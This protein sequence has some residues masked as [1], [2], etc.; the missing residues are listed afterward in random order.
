MDIEPTNHE[1]TIHAILTLDEF[2]ES[3]TPNLLSHLALT[4]ISSEQLSTYI[5]HPDQQSLF[6]TLSSSLRSLVSAHKMSKLVEEDIPGLDKETSQ[7]TLAGAIMRTG[8]II[9]Y[10]T[11]KDVPT[12]IPPFGWD[13][14]QKK[15]DEIK[16][17]ITPEIKDAA[18][19]IIDNPNEPH[20]VQS[21]DL[22][23]IVAAIC[24]IKV[25][26]KL[27]NITNE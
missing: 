3:D 25:E 27:K 21:K 26:N 14:N 10:L 12:S 15:V 9:H 23:Q 2:Q 5:K 18:Q 17:L 1:R 19:N 16:K 22:P 8:L 6:K 24:Q 20:H 13:I 7:Q 11:Q 4:D